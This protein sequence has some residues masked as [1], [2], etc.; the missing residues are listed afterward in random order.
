MSDRD[1]LA[2]HFEAAAQALFEISRI[3]KVMSEK[4]KTM[5]KREFAIKQSRERMMTKSEKTLEELSKP[6]PEPQQHVLKM[7]KE[8]KERL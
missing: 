1:K 5:S 2:K 3:M 7:L 8:A 4:D 6:H